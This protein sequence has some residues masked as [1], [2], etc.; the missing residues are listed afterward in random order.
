MYSIVAESSIRFSPTAEMCIKNNPASELSTW[1]LST[2]Q[3]VWSQW[4]EGIK[5]KLKAE[6]FVLKTRVDF[7]LNLEDDRVS[8]CSDSPLT[9]DRLPPGKSPWTV[10]RFSRAFQ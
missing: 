9:D 3:L 6:D 10:A 7:I 2:S 4:V 8:R 5:I 1:E